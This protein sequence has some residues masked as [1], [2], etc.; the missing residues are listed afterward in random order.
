MRH[1]T[2][3]PEIPPA[4]RIFANSQGS[5]SKPHGAN[6]PSP[7]HCSQTPSSLAGTRGEVGI[8]QAGIPS[9]GAARP[10][11]EASRVGARLPGH[12][13]T[14]GARWPREAGVAR[15]PGTPPALPGPRA[16]RPKA[17][18]LPGA[19]GLS[20]PRGRARLPGLRREFV[21]AESR[22]IPRRP[23]AEAAGKGREG[24]GARRGAAGPAPSCWWR[25]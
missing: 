22:R 20:A 6:A 5:H 3:L 1:Y 14:P 15:S 18:R 17:A 23:R 21:G 7:P 13:L 2:P 16:R 4:S 12:A 11:L 25:H 19:P 10:L 9:P 8:G 24:G